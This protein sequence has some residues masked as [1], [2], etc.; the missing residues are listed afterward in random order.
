[1][2]TH[3]HYAFRVSK[4]GELYTPWADSMVYEYPFDYTFDTPEEAREFMAEQIATF[5]QFDGGEVTANE[6]R[7]FVLVK[8]IE[9]VIDEGTTG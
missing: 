6:L 1:M 9:E 4:D 5:E 7:S 2:T 8:V 3:T